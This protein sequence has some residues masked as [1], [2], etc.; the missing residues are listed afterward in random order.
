M[1]TIYRRH[2]PP[3]PHRSRRFRNCKC[4]IWVQGSLRREYIRQSLDLRSWEAASDLVRGWEASGEVGVVKPDVPTVPAAVAKFLHDLEHGQLRKAATIQKYANVLEKRLLPWCTSNGYRLL[5]QLEVAALREFRAGWS[6][7]AITAQTFFRFCHSA[8]WVTHNP[9]V[10]VKAPTA[11][12]PSARVKVF[13]DGQLGRIVH[14][15]D[16]YPSAQFVRT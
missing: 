11:G 5:K 9:A 6:D 14:A 13:T 3:C 1:L 16:Q 2:Q 7:S 15:C 8:G 10:A 12:K 4:P